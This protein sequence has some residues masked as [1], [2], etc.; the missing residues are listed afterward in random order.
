MHGHRNIKQDTQRQAR[1]RRSGVLVVVPPRTESGC[2]SPAGVAP[3]GRRPLHA[4][5][6]SSSSRKVPQNTSSCTMTSIMHRATGSTSSSS[7]TAAAL[8]RYTKRRRRLGSESD[9][10]LSTLLFPSG[11]RQQ[12]AGVQTL[13]SALRP[14]AEVAPRLQSA[15]FRFATESKVRRHRGGAA[16]PSEEA[17]TAAASAATGALGDSRVNG[18]QQVVSVR[19][20]FDPQGCAGRS[21]RCGGPLDDIMGAGHGA[22]CQE[23]VPRAEQRQPGQ[24]GRFPGQDP[25]RRRFYWL[26]V[27]SGETVIIDGTLQRE[28][29]VR[30]GSTIYVDGSVTFQL[31]DKVYWCL[32][33]STKKDGEEEEEQQQQQ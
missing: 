32:R 33:W 19:P 3:A 31:Y 28:D 23:G 24:Q 15:L 14:S 2:S 22:E 6:T 11:N 13:R 21:A 7:G 10:T 8:D 26:Q 5:L 25:P 4:M 12:L 18:M 9:G 1:S 16:E 27:A 17:L 29:A 30:A 20:I